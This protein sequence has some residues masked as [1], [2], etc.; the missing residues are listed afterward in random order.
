MQV[1]GIK[2]KPTGKILAI[3]MPQVSLYTHCSK[4][5]MVFFL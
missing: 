2:S 3:V 1:T 4:K 5:I